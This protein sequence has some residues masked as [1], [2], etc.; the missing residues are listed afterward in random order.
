MGY[1]YDCLMYNCCMI[2]LPRKI[3]SAPTEVSALKNTNSD[4]CYTNLNRMR[5]TSSSCFKR[6]LCFYQ[7][8]KQN[9]K[10][11]YPKKENTSN[12]IY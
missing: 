12:S 5:Y 2:Y 7:I 6:N 3:K 4:C 1:S 11:V 9:G 10:K 8:P